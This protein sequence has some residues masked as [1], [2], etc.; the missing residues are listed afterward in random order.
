MRLAIVL[1]LLCCLLGAEQA[2][3]PKLSAVMLKE[4]RNKFLAKN[5]SIG[6]YERLAVR[7]RLEGIKEVRSYGNLKVTEAKTDTGTDLVRGPKDEGAFFGITDQPTFQLVQPYQAKSGK[8]EVEIVLRKTPREAMKVSLKGSLDLLIGGKPS[9]VEFP[10]FRT[11]EGAALKNEAF[12]DVGLKIILTRGVNTDTQ[13]RFTIEGNNSILQEIGLVDAAG[14]KLQTSGYFSSTGRGEGSYHL[15]SPQKIPN[16]AK[17]RVT[18]IKGG[19][20]STL[21]LVFENLP[22]P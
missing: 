16:D 4:Q 1:P 12:T 5:T 13:L 21:P 15:S 6:G 9:D 11:M 14:K 3:K 22:L 17:L 20:I 7:V 19:K 10:N 18:V 8:V 2:E